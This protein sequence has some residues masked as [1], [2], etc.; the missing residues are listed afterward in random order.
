MLRQDRSLIGAIEQTCQDPACEESLDN[1]LFIGHAPLPSHALREHARTGKPCKGFLVVRWWREIQGRSSV[2][3]ED[4]LLVDRTFSIGDAVKQVNGSAG[5]VTSA[6]SKYILQPIWDS[7]RCDKLSSSLEDY[8]VSG[9]SNDLCCSLSPGLCQIQLPADIEH[10]CPHTLIYGVPDHELILAYDFNVEDYVISQD[11]LGKIEKDDLDVVLLLQDKSIVVVDNHRELEII[12]PDWDKPVVNVPRKYLKRRPDIDISAYKGLISIRPLFLQRGQYVITNKRN[13]QNGR[14]INGVYSEDV[15]PCGRILDVRSRRVSV[16][17]ICPNPFA[18]DAVGDSRPNHE[19]RPYD[20]SSTFR[21]TK[22][23]RPNRKLVRYDNGKTPSIASEIAYAVDQKFEVGDHVKFR[24]FSVATLKYVGNSSGHG[25]LSPIDT[26]Q[27][28]GFDLN[29]FKVLCSQQEVHVLWQDGTQTTERSTSLTAQ[30]LPESDLCPT[31]MV[32]HKESLLQVQTGH[33]SHQAI[34]YD[35]MQ[36]IQSNYF[37]LLPKKIGVIQSVDSKERL[38]LVRWFQNPNVKV[39]HGGLS[40]A[41]GSWFGPLSNLTEEV[42]LYEVLTQPALDR[43][44]G[45]LAVVVPHVIN[46]TTFRSIQSIPQNM[47]PAG[48]TRIDFLNCL[49]SSS[50]FHELRLLARALFQSWQPV[51][52]Y[53]TPKT[54]DWLGEIVGVGLDG[55]LTIRLGALQNCKDIKVPFEQVLTVIDMDVLWHD[56]NSSYLE[57][58]YISSPSPIQE[59]IEY[60]GGECMGNDGDEEMWLTDEQSPTLTDSPLIGTDE[61][62]EMSISSSPQ[63]E[64]SSQLQTYDGEQL[65]WRIEHP[66]VQPIKSINRAL[67][68]PSQF[69]VL[70]SDPP[71]NH[72][73]VGAQVTKGPSRLRRIHKEY[74]ILSSS[75]PPGIFVRSFDSRLDLLRVMIIGPQDTPYEFAPLVFDMHLHGEFPNQPPHVRFHS[76]THGLGRINPNLY[77]DGKICLSL[78]G[79][80]PGK[81]KKE[82]WSEES[83]LLQLLVSLTGLV[84]VKEPFYNEAGFENLATDETYATESSQYTEKAYIITR[85]FIKHALQYRVSGF[86]D[87]LSWTYMPAIFAQESLNDASQKPPN[88]LRIAIS[89]A[90]N[91]M[92]F[93]TSSEAQMQDQH[94][95][96][97]NGKSSNDGFLRR[98]SEGALVMLRRLTRD[99]EQISQEWTT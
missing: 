40:I 77:E 6:S 59:S 57:S 91:L 30:I 49:P 73:Y 70:E 38:A 48:I 62:I 33:P 54:H 46:P 42:S 21:S 23:L 29:E 95:L 44:L 63:H 25:M 94:L 8:E 74:K 35:E 39:T 17:W 24:N 9:L 12:I 66:R 2:A 56:G 72:F 28:Y 18:G 53:P 50:T 69:A 89:R 71:S 65:T 11:W 58:D 84:L 31:D 98:P 92:N 41:A 52:R 45:N 4:L 81:D 36:Y 78:L 85:G 90:Q 88:L 14:F 79:T 93:T 99:L 10:F 20:N 86:E 13:I 51:T 7:K 80:W 34:P 47:E 68:E 32:L 61:D 5:I 67:A 96:D 3:E 19:L 22:T 26:D 43:K 1:D 16:R 76:W 64:S 15:E 55:L 60:E 27:S 83:S 82:N 87:V 75:L 37:D 97:G